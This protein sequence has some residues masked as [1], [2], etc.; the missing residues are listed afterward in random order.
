MTPSGESVARWATVVI[1]PETREPRE[2]SDIELEMIEETGVT[3]DRLFIEPVRSASARGQ[4]EAA[5]D[6]EYA[7]R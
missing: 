6:P 7:L 2:A 1:D 5:H 4:V 3:V